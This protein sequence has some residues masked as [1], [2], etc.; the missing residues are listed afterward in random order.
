MCFHV[1]VN[2]SNMNLLIS[3]RISLFNLIVTKA[4]NEKS[5]MDL[6]SLEVCAALYRLW[7]HKQVILVL[8]VWWWWG[9]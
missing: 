3:N 9:G 8:R 1:S 4:A 6:A 5:H 2:A 7:R